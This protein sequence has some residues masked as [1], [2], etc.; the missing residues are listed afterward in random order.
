[1]KI[2]VDVKRAEQSWDLDTQKQQN[3][4]VIEVFGLETRVPCTEDE[5]M[6]AISQAA[7]DTGPAH[8]EG[9]EDLLPFTPEPR[10]AP[11]T[12]VTEAE[13]AS[14]P[15]EPVQ[16]QERPARRLAP[17]KRERGDDV[18]IAQG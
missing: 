16:S 5:L 15:S 3:Y 14:T 9:D 4:L 2:E 18:G 17:M 11:S 12:F 6:H 8:A 7:S 1:M 13:A 10:A